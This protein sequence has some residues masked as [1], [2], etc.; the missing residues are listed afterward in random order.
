MLS[1]KDMKEYYVYEMHEVLSP[2]GKPY[3][4]SSCN[5]YGRITK[6]K[7]QYKL[8]HRPELIIIDGPYYTRK[9]AR[10]AEQPYRV[11]NGWRDENDV[12]REAAKIIRKINVE[13]GKFAKIKTKENQSKNGSIGAAIVGKMLWVNKYGKNKR[14]DPLLLQDY[15]DSG[16]IRGMYKKEKQWR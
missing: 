16:Y 6:H 4:G 3:V 1:E 2:T 15:L 11:A 12:L 14:V 7:H 9:E 8:D 13:S 10:T 5:F